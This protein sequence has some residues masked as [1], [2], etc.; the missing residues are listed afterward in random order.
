M[1]SSTALYWRAMRRVERRAAAYRT[2][3]AGRSG[4]CTCRD[5]VLLREACRLASELAP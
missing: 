2:G 4:S 3:H 1:L 5:Y